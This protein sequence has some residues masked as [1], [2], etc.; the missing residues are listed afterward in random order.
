MICVE[1]GRGPRGRDVAKVGE[2]WM[3]AGECQFENAPHPI[4]GV[5]QVRPARKKCAQMVI[6]KV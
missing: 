5:G 2:L 4:H 6:G 3:V 1:E